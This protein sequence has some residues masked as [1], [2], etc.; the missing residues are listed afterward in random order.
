MN[1]ATLRDI[2]ESIGVTKKTVS[3]ALNDLPGV[4]DA[5]RLTIK[6]KAEALNYVP[7]IYGLGLSGKSP[8]TLGVVI[9]DNSSPAYALF[10][11]GI[12]EAANRSGYTVVICNTNEDPAAEDVHVRVLASRQVQ[13]VLLSPC[14]NRSH[15]PGLKIL[16]RLH[17]PHVLINRRSGPKSGI[18]VSQDH[19]AGAILATEFLLDRGHRNILH[20]TCKEATSV[21]TAR[22]HGFRSAMRQRGQK[23]A[24]AIVRAAC[25]ISIESGCCEMLGALADG[26]QGTAVFA[27]NDMIAFGALKALHQRGIRVPQDMAVIGY[28]DIPFAEVSHPPL[29]TVH[30]AFHEVGVEAV[31]VLLAKMGPPTGRSAPELPAPYIV[32]RE[33]A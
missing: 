11:K 9:S 14:G 24:S 3:K 28:D 2:A 19:R 5:L 32:K 17:I 30:Q 33:S 7:N 13:G 29:T 22:T 12:E 21:V 18:C 10:L 8:R 26:F 15:N 20:L 27:F 23:A 4:S 25:R 6:R 31:R 1:R 16:D